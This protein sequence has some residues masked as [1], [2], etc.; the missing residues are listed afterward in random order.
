STPVAEV[1][2]KLLK[3]PAYEIKSAWTELML[4][5][6][7]RSEL[8]SQVKEQNKAGVDVV[9]DRWWFSTYAYQGSRG[10][11][12][13]FI[14]Y[15]H[16][17]SP[18]SKWV[19]PLDSELCFWL[20]VSPEL[21]AQRK[22]SEAKKQSD[23]F[24]AEGVKLSQKLQIAYEELFLAK[25]VQLVTVYDSSTIDDVFWGVWIGICQAVEKKTCPSEIE[26]P[27]CIGLGTGDDGSPC[28][29][30]EGK[31]EINRAKY[32][33]YKRRDVVPNGVRCPAC[34]GT[35]YQLGAGDLP[36]VTDCGLCN[37]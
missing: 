33:A 37:G 15:L 27:E 3:D 26:C 6:A 12:R 24:E 5:E 17:S 25:R 14:Y 9:L 31:A 29:I 19:E 20:D 30:C 21:A 7:C 32:W 36:V 13:D 23:R 34:Y 28:S 8:W 22:I 11:P 1:V 4:F 16:V 10:V 18:F 35:G 2:R